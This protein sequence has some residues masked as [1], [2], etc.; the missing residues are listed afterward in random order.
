MSTWENEALFLMPGR[1]LESLWLIVIVFLMVS[2][3]H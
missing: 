2:F 1:I 3:F